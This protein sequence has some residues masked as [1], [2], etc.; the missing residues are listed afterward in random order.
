MVGISPDSQEILKKFSDSESIPF[1][2]LS[3]KDSATIRAFELEFQRSL[4]H[5]GTLIIDGD[6]TVRAKLFN[7]GYRKRH[8]T[9]DLL[10]ALKALD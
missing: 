10:D 6:G 2:L 3:D 5:P 7:E 9:E 4:P 1:P 8:T